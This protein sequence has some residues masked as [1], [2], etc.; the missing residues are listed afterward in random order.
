MSAVQSLRIWASSAIS[1]S[2]DIRLL[3]PSSLAGPIWCAAAKDASQPSDAH[4]QQDF[5][6]RL[7]ARDRPHRFDERFQRIGGVD[8]G[9]DRP[10]RRVAQQLGHIG[11]MRLWLA[12]DEI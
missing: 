2:R 1:F 6:Q 11:A 8:M 3:A 5:T 9:R 7:A 12:S 4:F 10:A